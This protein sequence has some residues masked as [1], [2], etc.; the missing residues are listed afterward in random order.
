MKR[1]IAKDAAKKLPREARQPFLRAW[2]AADRMDLYIGNLGDYL[3]VMGQVLRER[4]NDINR[5]EKEIKKMK[6]NIIKAI[7]VR[8]ENDNEYQCD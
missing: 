5:L 8:K 6:K 7:G 3:S 2:K 4:Q 1:K